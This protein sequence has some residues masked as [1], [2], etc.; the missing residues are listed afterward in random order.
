MQYTRTRKLTETPKPQRSLALKY[1]IPFRKIPS[2]ISHFRSHT[3]L[4]LKLT[5]P[6]KLNILYS[7]QKKKKGYRYPITEKDESIKNSYNHPFPEPT[8]HGF[9]RSLDRGNL[10]ED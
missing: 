10:D 6:R 7:A 3:P 2:I 9:Q 4:S 8:P 1:S 5:G